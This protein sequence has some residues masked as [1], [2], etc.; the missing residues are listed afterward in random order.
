MRR[1]S[2]SFCTRSGSASLTPIAKP[3]IEGWR[4]IAA[5]MAGTKSR[6]RPN[7]RSM[8]TAAPKNECVNALT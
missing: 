4:T 8:R 1:G 5:T 7:L 2:D 6:L 3:I